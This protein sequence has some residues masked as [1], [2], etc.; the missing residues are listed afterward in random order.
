VIT[1]WSLRTGRFPDAVAPQIKA[2]KRKITREELI[3]LVKGMDND[4]KDYVI[5]K[6]FMKQ[7]F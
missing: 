5:Q 2:S 1:K 3:D 4:V 7:D 6:V